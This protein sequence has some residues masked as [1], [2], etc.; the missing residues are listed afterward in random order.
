MSPLAVPPGV[1][2]RAAARRRRALELATDLEVV[3]RWS[4]VGRVVLV[5]A[6]AYDLVVSPDLDFEVFT[7]GTPSVRGGFELLANL[8]EHPRVRAA[9]FRN[10]LTAPD[11]GLY[12]QIRCVDDDGEEWKVDLWTLSADHP[13]PLSA[14]LVEP[15]RRVLDDELRTAILLLKEARAAGTTRPVASI[16][17]Y[18]AV[19]DG[20]ARTPEELERYVG[21][22]YQPRLTTWVPTPV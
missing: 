14:W 9:R 5:G 1:L 8:A 13:G 11:R 7:D 19:I 6:V 3:S 12:W 2:V 22:D 16:D 18:R 4:S 20:G 17:I 10:A 21:P 15:M